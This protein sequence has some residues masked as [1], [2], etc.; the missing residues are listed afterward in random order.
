MP[1]KPVVRVVFGLARTGTSL[2]MQMLDAAG[3]ECTGRYPAFEDT[4]NFSPLRFDARLETWRSLDGKALKLLDPQQYLRPETR[5]RR[6]HSDLPSPDNIDYRVVMTSRRPRQ[7]AIST[8][9]FLQWIGA[10]PL[11]SGSPSPSSV[12]QFEHGIQRDMKVLPDLIKRQT[13]IDPVVI[14]FEDVIAA[15]HAAATVLA[16]AMDLPMSRTADMAAV[17]KHR[18]SDVY[19]GMIETELLAE[20]M[21]P[22]FLQA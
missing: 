8:L 20:R 13:G 12:A 21:G 18:S 14:P 22:T 6:Y 9:K 7:T 1:N 10:L 17:V 4:E 11:E 2:L 5:Q 16:E 3:V 15:P 19:R